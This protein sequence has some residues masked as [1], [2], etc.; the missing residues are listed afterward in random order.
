MNNPLYDNNYIVA[1][2]P[3]C[4]CCTYAPWIVYAVTG[5]TVKHLL[6]EQGK[7]VYQFIKLS[8]GLGE[9]RL[10][11]KG[12]CKCTRCMD[13]IGH[14]YADWNIILVHVATIAV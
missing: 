9:M 5:F 4:S 2:L 8:M 12:H 3:K 10:M 11:L 7:L 1:M 6:Q 14:G 13:E